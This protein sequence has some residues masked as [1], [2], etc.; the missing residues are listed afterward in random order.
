MSK[1]SRVET[2]YKSTNLGEYIGDFE[3]EL[4]E[5]IDIQMVAEGGTWIK[6]GRAR[7]EA[8]FL[9]YVIDLYRRWEKLDDS[10]ALFPWLEVGR[11]VLACWVREKQTSI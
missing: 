6:R 2:F 3:D 7:Q 1:V 8:R 4:R 10:S 9:M 11:E 5:R